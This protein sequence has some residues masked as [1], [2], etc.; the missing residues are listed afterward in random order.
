MAVQLGINQMTNP[1]AWSGLTTKNHLA[2]IYK[3]SPQKASQV[4]TK[5]LATEYGQ[6]LETLLSKFPVKYF[7][8]D[9]DFTWDLIGS[10]E[11]NIPLVE[12]RYQGSTVATGDTGVG[13]VTS[14][15]ELVF[16]ERWFS[17]VHMIVGEKNE[18]Y[19]IRIKEEPL[20]EGTN[21]VYVVELMGDVVA[22]MP[23]S[24]LQPGKRFSKEFSP[25]EDTLSIK[26]G[27]IYFS[28]PVTLR[29]N[30]SMIRMQHRAPG[31]MKD[32]RVV[33]P[34][35]VVDSSGSVAQHATWMQHVEW[36]FEYEYYQEKNRVFYYARTNRDQDG[37]YKNVGKSGF[38]IKQGAGIR[39]Q[40]E[41]S[42][43]V[44]YSTFSIELIESMLMELSEGKLSMDERHFVLRTGERGASQFHKAVRD[45]VSGWASIGADNT[46][47]NNIMNVV[48]NLHTN[49]LSAGYQFTEY[50]AP[51]SIRVSLEVDPLY[52][53][54]IRNKI[55]HDDGGVAESYRYDILDIGTIN[56]EPNIQK[57]MARGQEDIRG[58]E[59]GLRNPFTGAPNT[60]LMANSVDGSTYH[61]AC[62]MGAIVRDPSRTASLIP[63]ILAA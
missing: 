55:Y 17:D 39:Q 7:D 62:V 59:S 50:L 6:T 43:T 35:Q 25:V 13:A 23:G 54:K 26:G 22:G 18:I 15:F 24:E 33:L 9:D 2:A 63:S 44:F 11:R 34:F 48:S 61:R 51:N 41:I 42:N 53:D 14:E 10:H 56:G 8:S 32:D 29:N 52:D 19:P 46:G 12:A 4:I 5:L 28:S 16:G 1:Q 45:H 30:F 40:M 47:V 27:D 20:A 49:S 3:K 31:N 36:T 60:E 57:A 21:W 37:N 38:A 58:W